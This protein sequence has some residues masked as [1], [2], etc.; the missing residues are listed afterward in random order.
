[1]CVIYLSKR[2]KTII[3]RIGVFAQGQILCLS[4]NGLQA[5]H[6]DAPPPHFG[7]LLIAFLAISDQ[8]A[9][10]YFFSQNGCRRPFWTTENNFL[11]H[12]SPFQIN[13]LLL[14]FL[15]KWLLAAILDDQKLLLIALLA[16]SDKIATFP[17]FDFFFQNGRRLPFWMTE[18]HF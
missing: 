14:F 10:F 4:P 11:S 16:I 1:M 13:K 6:C 5:G 9:T 17:F 8:Y 7:S 15:A 2:Q 12:F 3:T 18:N